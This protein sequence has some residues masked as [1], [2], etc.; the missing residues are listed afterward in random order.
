M[1]SESKAR[2]SACSRDIQARE[3]AL[4]EAHKMFLADHGELDLRTFCK[5][6]MAELEGNL[7]TLD[8]EGYDPGYAANVYR[9]FLQ[10]PN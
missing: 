10:K 7:N 4:L 2:L 1:L 9:Y 5:L 3:K 6:V 8:R